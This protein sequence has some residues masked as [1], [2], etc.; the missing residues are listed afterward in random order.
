MKILVVGGAGYIG[1][2]TVA[3]L[4]KTGHEA[5]IYDNLSTGYEMLIHPEA[6]FYLG[7]MLDKAQLS[8]VLAIESKKAPF[9]AVIVFAAKLVVPESLEQPL[10]YY[11]TNI[12]GLRIVLECMRDFNIKHIVF[13]STAAVYG[14]P[15][16]AVCVEDMPTKPINPYG[17]SKLAGEEMIRWVCD[18]YDMNYCIFRYF[19]VAGADTELN[20]GLYHDHITHVIPV[21]M[22]VAL[23]IKEKFYIF[24][25]D[26]DTPDGTCIRDYIHVIDLARAHVLGVEYLLKE[27]KSLLA[28][29]GSGGGYSVREI[30]DV[31]RKHFEVPFEIAPRRAGDPA[32]LIAHTGKA[33]EILGFKPEYGIEEIILS[34]YAFRKKLAEKGIC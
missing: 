22:S 13:S 15:E 34:D 27:K 7:D 33:Q 31:A 16:E 28:N 19:N 32:K 17:S 1:S 3:E 8:N 6:R 12:E 25:D 10:E 14:S 30:L 18:R 11:Q 23:G 29:L 2:Q 26:Y 9:D 21:I 20:L 5:V 24:G 4:I